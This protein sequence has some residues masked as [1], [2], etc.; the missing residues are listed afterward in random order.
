MPANSRWDLIRGLKGKGLGHSQSLTVSQSVRLGVQ[1]VA[2]DQVTVFCLSYAR[3]YP[4]EHYF[5]EG[6]QVSLV[7]P[8]V[9][10]NV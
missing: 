4:K 10:S 6:S 3:W 7:F 5:L 2:K 9:K 1:P 8:S